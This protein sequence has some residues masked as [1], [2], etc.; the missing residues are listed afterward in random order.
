VPGAGFLELVEVLR[1]GCPLPGPAERAA[2]GDWGPGEA[3]PI[4]R[5]DEDMRWR[6]LAEAPKS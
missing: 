5:Q 2:L 1:A 3:Y 4:L 6:E